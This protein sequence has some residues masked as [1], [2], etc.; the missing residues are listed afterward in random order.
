MHPEQYSPPAGVGTTRVV[1]IGAGYA[2]AVAANHLRLRDDVEITVVNARPEFVERVRLHQLAAGTAA[3]VV[4]LDSLLADGIRL[5]VDRAVRVDAEDR[6]VHLASGL[7][8]EYDYLVYAVGSVGAVPSS[9]QGAAQ[10]AVPIADFESA[11]TLRSRLAALPQDA[12]I[13]VVGGGLTG[14]ETAAE[15]AE[16]GRAPTL[17]CSGPLAPAL[18]D[19]ARRYIARWLRRHRVTVLEDRRVAA[20]GPDAISL[21]DGAVLDSAVTVWAAGFTAQGLAHDSGL[22]TDE[23]GRLITD[24]TLTSIDDA[25][26]VATGDAVA[27][28][29]VP[30]RMSCQAAGPL[31]QQAANTVLARVAGETPRNVDLALTGSCVSLGRHAA[32]R[33]ISHKDDSSM[34]LYV[35]GPL[36]TGYKEFTS[37]LGTWKVRREAR[38]PGSVPWPKGGPR[39][40]S[41]VQ[42]TRRERT[43]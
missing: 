40:A 38:K 8:V 25:R 20:V 10:Y 15:L 32:V 30:F 36:S 3:A 28:S 24:E 34:S 1:V 41:A 26:I 19:G 33:Q 13:T 9:V 39:P 23:V 12:P 16:Q 7:E 35:T 43:S 29:G 17:V 27:P 5:I 2:G 22:S 42:P 21:A 11:L 37:R 4:S 31:G 18:S 6:V 14:I